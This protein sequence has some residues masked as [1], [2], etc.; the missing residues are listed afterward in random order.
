MKTTGAHVFDDDTSL[1]QFEAWL[2][3]YAKQPMMLS[4]ETMNEIMQLTLANWATPGAKVRARYVN[5]VLFRVSREGI[6]IIKELQ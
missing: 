3:R 5:R 1:V 2:R 6:F 4:G